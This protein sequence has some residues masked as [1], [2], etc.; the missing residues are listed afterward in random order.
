M[1]H[2]PHSAI[3]RPLLTAL[4]LL[5]MAVEA[6][7][8]TYTYYIINK[9]GWT[10]LWFRETTQTAGDA[11]SLP[12]WMR[13]PLVEKYYYYDDAKVTHKTY[14]E[15][16]SGRPNAECNYHNGSSVVTNDAVLPGKY[17]YKEK[18]DVLTSLPASDANI[19]VF[20]DVKPSTV[21]G[22]TYIDLLGQ[23][24]YNIQDSRDWYV[25][26]NELWKDSRWGQYQICSNSLTD[27][28]DYHKS[29]TNQTGQDLQDF[30][31]PYNLNI[32][33]SDSFMLWRFVSVDNIIDP[34]NFYIKNKMYDE[35]TSSDMNARIASEYEE[36]NNYSKGGTTIDN[37]LGANKDYQR[38]GYMYTPKSNTNSRYYIK[39]FAI[40]G[41]ESQ[42]HIVANSIFKYSPSYTYPSIKNF[43]YSACQITDRHKE[44]ISLF[45]GNITNSKTEFIDNSTFAIK[46]T[47]NKFATFNMVDLNGKIVLKWRKRIVDISDITVPESLKSPLAKDFK[48]YKKTAF[49][50]HGDKYVLT[51]SAEIANNILDIKDGDDLF[52]TYTYNE[53][54]NIINISGNAITSIQCNGKYLYVEDNNATVKTAEADQTKSNYRWI[55]NNA[56]VNGAIDPYNIYVSSMTNATTFMSASTADEALT[57]SNSN[58]YHRFALL[59]NGSGNYSFVASGSSV[60]N[61]NK[62]YDHLYVTLNDDGTIF[63][64]QQ[65]YEVATTSSQHLTFTAQSTSTVTYHVIN[66]SNQEAISYSVDIVEGDNS[67]NMPAILKSPLAEN[68]TFYSDRDCTSPIESLTTGMKDIY[69]KYTSKTNTSI[70]LSGNTSFY[71]NL[72]GKEALQK[73]TLTA[74]LVNGYYD[75][76]NVSIK[77]SNGNI[78]MDAS[79]CIL[80]GMSD[81]SY[82]LMKAKSNDTDNN[83]YLALSDE[84]VYNLQELNVTKIT[85]SNVQA[86]FSK[87][88]T[89][90]FKK[91]NGNGFLDISWKR[92]VSANV[93]NIVPAELMS[94]IAK[95]YYYYRDVDMTQ[96][97]TDATRLPSDIY[98]KYSF[99]ESYTS[100]NISGE[101]EYLATND[102]GKLLYYNGLSLSLLDSDNYLGEMLWNI[103]GK[104]GGSIIDPYAV[105]V[106]NAGF[107]NSFLSADEKGT[108]TCNSS[109]TPKTYMITTTA[110]GKLKFV[111]ISPQLT[112]FTLS[113]AEVS[114]GSYDYTFYIIN[115]KGW[116]GLWYKLK[117]QSSEGNIVLPNFMRSQL[118]SK[119]YFYT[120]ESVIHKSIDEDPSGR[121]DN[122]CYYQFNN[123]PVY[124]NDL[125]LRGK[126]E[127][128][129]ADT[130]IWPRKSTNIFVFYDVKPEEERNIN[131][132][133][134]D[135]SGKTYYNIRDFQDAYLFID[136]RYAANNYA[137]DKSQVF[138]FEYENLQT[139]LNIKS[140]TDNQLMWS[141][142]SKNDDPY[143]VQIKNKQITLYHPDWVVVESATY[144][145]LGCPDGWPASLGGDNFNGDMN[146]IKNKKV[147]V[148]TPETSN[149]NDYNKTGR[150]NSF[151]FL[152]GTTE[153]ILKLAGSINGKSSD[154]NV[155]F[156]YFGLRGYPN[157]NNS[158]NRAYYG[159]MRGEID[160]DTDKYLNNDL[161]RVQLTEYSDKVT[162]HVINLSGKEATSF[163][164]YYDAGDECKL[165]SMIMSP[166]ATNYKF[167]KADD[168][169]IADDGTITVKADAVPITTIAAHTTDIYVTYEYDTAN[170]LG[171]NI[172]GRNS[173]ILYNISANGKYLSTDGTKL[174]VVSAASPAKNSIWV[175]EC[176]MVDGVPDPYDAHI[177]SW[178]N[179]EKYL[180]GE[181]TLSLTDKASSTSF[182]LGS[183]TKTNVFTIAK[184]TPVVEGEG[185]TPQMTYLSCN[186]TTFSFAQTAGGSTE[187]QTTLTK[188]E[189]NYIYHIINLSKEKS[190]Y[191]VADDLFTMHVPYELSSPAVT[192]YQYYAPTSF[193]DAYN[194]KEGATPIASFQD[195]PDG[196]FDIYVTYS[197]DANTSAYD[198]TGATEYNII[199][200]NGSYAAVRN[201]TGENI[202]YAPIP[203][204]YGVLKPN[205]DNAST[206][207]IYDP[208]ALWTLQGKDPYKVRVYNS[209]RPDSW[210]ASTDNQWTINIKNSDDNVKM[211]H[212]AILNMTGGKLRVVGVPYS[213]TNT[214]VNNTSA[215][216]YCLNPDQNKMSLTRMSA[217]LENTS[218]TIVARIKHDYTYHLT[219]KVDNKQLSI[220]EKGYEGA[221]ISVPFELS[222]HFCTYRFFTD[223]AMTNEVTELNTEQNIYIDYTVQDGIFLKE[224]DNVDNHPEYVF[225]MESGTG[226]NGTYNRFN[227]HWYVN[228]ESYDLDEKNGNKFIVGS[229]KT[230]LTT[231]NRFKQSS[232]DI[233][234][235]Y[236]RGDPYNTQ[237]YG[238]N[239][240]RGGAEEQ[241]LVP[242]SRNEY[243]NVLK[244][245]RDVYF[246]GTQSDRFKTLKEKN[247]HWEMVDSRLNTEEKTMSFALRFKEVEGRK[248]NDDHGDSYTERVLNAY[249][250][251]RTA[252]SK[253]NNDPD[254]A[255]I[256]DRKLRLEYAKD[257]LTELI[258]IDGRIKELHTANKNEC[259]LTLRWPATIKLTVY[260]DGNVASPVTRNELSEY[261]AVGE[262]FDYVPD[263]LKRQFC[264]YTIVDADDPNTALS[265]TLF[266]VTKP[267]YEGAI[268]MY[269]KYKVVDYAPFTSLTS[270]DDL[271]LLTDK[272]T[273]WFNVRLNGDFSHNHWMYFDRNYVGLNS[274]GQPNESEIKPL[275]NID[276]YTHIDR[277]HKGIQWAFVGDPYD[278]YVV[279][280][281]SR[282]AVFDTE[283]KYKIVSQ[284]Q[285]YFGFNTE[286]FNH[287]IM[288]VEN[289]DY[290]NSRFTFMKNPTNNSYFFSLSKPRKTAQGE[291]YGNTNIFVSSGNSWKL[292]KAESGGNYSYG[293]GL[294][295]TRVKANEDL[296]LEA[297]EQRFYGNPVDNEVFDCI[298]NV[299]NGE[300]RVVATTGWTELQRTSNIDAMLPLDIKRYG[301]RY[302]CWADATMTNYKVDALDQMVTRSSKN[303]WDGNGD[304]DD[305][306]Y[307]L[308]DGCV[309]FTSYKYDQ[310]VYSTENNY[311]WMNCHYDWQRVNNKSSQWK[312]T[313][314]DFQR[315]AGTQNDKWYGDK[316]ES[317]L[318]IDGSENLTRYVKMP[319]IPDPTN[320]DAG[321]TLQPAGNV[322]DRD[323]VTDQNEQN[324]MKWAFIGD[325]YEFQIKNYMYKSG[326]YTNHYLYT[327][328][329]K[330]PKFKEQATIDIEI[331]EDT[332][333][334]Q[335]I[336]TELTIAQKQ[337]FTYTYKVN[338]VNGEEVP[339]LAL[340]DEYADKYIKQSADDKLIGAVKSYISF[341]AHTDKDQRID[342]PEYETVT[343]NGV[344]YTKGTTYQPTEDV[345]TK[346]KAYS[347]SVYTEEGVYEYSGEGI[348]YFYL[349]NQMPFTDAEGKAVQ[350]VVWVP[351]SNPDETKWTL[352]STGG[353][354]SDANTLQLG[355]AK[356]FY[357]VPMTTYAKKVIFNLKYFRSKDETGYPTKDNEALLM[358]SYFKN[359]D[360]SYDEYPVTKRPAVIRKNNGDVV[361]D[362]LAKPYEIEDYGVGNDLQLPWSYRRQF[363]E[364]FY[365]LVKVEQVTTD[366]SGNETKT[367]VSSSFT[368]QIGKFYT[369][370]EPELAN[371]VVTF[372][373]YYKTSST[374]QSSDNADNAYWYNLTTRV[375]NT[376][377][378]DLINFSYTND[379]N[380]GDRKHHY[381]DDW[382]WAL[383]G[384]PYGLQIHNRY[385]Q[386][387]E[388]LAIN[389]TI[390]P[391][392]VALQ[393]DIDPITGEM[394]GTVEFN[395]ISVSPSSASKMTLADKGGNHTYFEMMEGNYSDAFI[396]HPI[397]AEVLDKYPAFFI[398][399]FMFNA[400]AWPVQLNEMYDRDVKRNVAANWMLSQMT[401]DQLYV[402]YQRR[403][404]V[405]GLL[406]SV[407]SS[408]KAL[409]EKLSTANATYADLKNAQKI[410]HNK[411][412]LVPLQKG[413]YRI[414]AMSDE[415]L[416]A[417]EADKT[418]YDGNRYITGYLSDTEM[419]AGAG[420]KP[421]PLNF[422]AT[423]A[424]KKGKLQHSD[425]PAEHTNQSYNRELLAAEYD[426]SSI[427]YFVPDDAD[428]NN[429]NA[430]KDNWRWNIQTQDLYVRNGFTMSKTAASGE[431]SESNLRMVIDDIGGTLFTIREG[432]DMTTGYLN[433]S[434]DTKRFAV[435]KGS[436]NE[437]HEKYDIQDTKWLLQRVDIPSEKIPGAMPLKFDMLDGKDEYYYCSAYLPYDIMLSTADDKDVKAYIATGSPYLDAKTQQWKIMCKE[438]GSYNPESYK[439]DSKFVP[440]HTPVL[441]VSQSNDVRA[442]I[443]TTAPTSTEITENRLFGSLLA[444]EIADSDWASETEKT[445][446]NETTSLVYVF[447]M[448]N[449]MADFYLNGNA[450]PHD[451][452]SF[453]TKYLYHN[454]AFL[455]ESPVINSSRSKVC[456]P[457][458]ESMPSGIGNIYADDNKDKGAIYDLQGRKVKKTKRGVYIQDKRK[459]ICK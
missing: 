394:I 438:I 377:A 287:E 365:K 44:G 125:T 319:Q 118:V 43:G 68:Y 346:G 349:K 297:A 239:I 416:T 430:I 280:R 366:G 413:Y 436:N 386:W 23:S 81:D 284:T 426:P 4:L 128:G 370:L 320:K 419:T 418:T 233:L 380:R 242:M 191:K 326:I 406:P 110:D 53:E 158:V 299:Y 54:Q 332:P 327:G 112:S 17:E 218:T 201:Y 223:E 282:T 289:Q 361:D 20:Y 451:G 408:N 197:Y 455:I 293:T 235:F 214:E 183:G 147:H 109:E 437:L 358:D 321:E 72:G 179:S 38:R 343:I 115:K 116:T 165:S 258:T 138:S 13:S 16:P 123:N 207:T 236:F 415:A 198:L 337:G 364:Y 269:A 281:R 362:Y 454:K 354:S 230:C 25:Y 306:V 277:L 166:F 405:G 373:V 34:Y 55:L 130:K 142:Y 445:Q 209:Y 127:R 28:H 114:Y 91:L 410:V 7:A 173:T 353:M 3:L 272:K 411:S 363:C 98:V 270:D 313:V 144:G 73:M 102:E 212:F 296:E 399:F 80:H 133:H 42:V 208:K 177:Y 202:I 35:S 1:N 155:V 14:A 385:T 383:D 105:T 162:Y 18:K 48:I 137:D 216:W 229:L 135:L 71:F 378:L 428:V 225:F 121:P 375:N 448:A 314:T 92:A 101:K 423:T 322:A 145:D 30:Q 22:N 108:L 134:I 435:N 82:T 193:D 131:G 412:N 181:T 253:N 29:L 391:D 231:D 315:Q 227:S 69:V 41:G 182:I 6:N 47:E 309:I 50:K 360:N 403:G 250:Y 276:I 85:D 440:A 300:N 307:L 149:I 194:L 66:L 59:Q 195:L 189:L 187:V 335:N 46:L 303:D 302:T 122:L 192:E 151:A 264:D 431:N 350:K 58:T 33:P 291:S 359:A 400:G 275:E 356:A 395:T 278:F 11:P 243:Q 213:C 94:S 32:K 444:R 294:K 318:Q 163:S 420:G 288:V 221:P 388:V 40:I 376:S 247:F 324:L 87:D 351:D 27:L 256:A 167:F 453:D 228:N 89:Y 21:I 245:R 248:V 107:S 424:D 26:A 422:W 267:S 90:H 452:N 402:Y 382:L 254:E 355:G 261:Y 310:S 336:Q 79:F 398:S 381:T 88:I 196:K 298:L 117:E 169:T 141:F 397:N 404:Y 175:I 75:P 421:V 52:V 37:L 414:K 172:K 334:D 407:A 67:I 78:L 241:L 120:T 338:I 154:A 333:V 5:C 185:G 146:W 268:Y 199:M 219:T 186:G 113:F 129:A 31:Y 57:L 64:T 417:Y 434:P 396:V 371:Y 45:T 10:G 15:D 374:Y 259:T 93:T 340:K 456:I 83:Q 265:N 301:C 459:V 178:G 379:L 433:C 439:N 99:D 8:Y 348:K 323:T 257:N 126:Y 224:G 273:K 84:G 100:I 260:K 86:T 232:P 180:G 316:W 56:S 70:D 446:Y 286:S 372:D 174:T 190:L 292:C 103:N 49:T 295:L 285:G 12:D 325:P 60:I 317:Y 255:G 206:C 136:G 240:S 443:P 159:L 304:P 263:N 200:N 2:H 352:A 393:E 148:N 389:N 226:M 156:R 234:K 97:I 339:Y 458:F 262:K 450:N 119:Y 205:N 215:Y 222:R 217:N 441:I 249:Y 266:E 305:M 246:V 449:D 188:Q 77:D 409:F 184:A 51:N 429:E 164:E 132:V 161:Y 274:N 368:G 9:K 447:G 347:G 61:S 457:V 76:Y 139:A 111:D 153:N 171:I 367:D 390:L 384:D 74:Q 140:K 290:T 341:N 176:N 170:K 331:T 152:Q 401:K 24:Y 39:T 330:K 237:M 271:A 220:T 392:P 150:I 312:R 342:V 63:L 442:T 311:R 432:Q 345:Y 329:D 95:D 62:D 425:L 168:V 387:N 160:A 157:T 204:E 36:N 124:K 328:N 203:N 252:R 238:Y 143:D 65:G 357:V 344:K 308:E 19:F 210:M 104:D 251:L 96:E 283:N 279:N 211:T 427:F 106:F 369:E 244:Y